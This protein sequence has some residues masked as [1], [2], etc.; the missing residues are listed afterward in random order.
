MKVVN[1]IVFS[2]ALL[3]PLMSFAQKSEKA[4]SEMPSDTSKQEEKNKK[5]EKTYSD[6]VNDSTKT[7]TGLV[8]VHQ[9]EDKYYFEI[10]DSVFGRDIM[11][12]TRIAKTP[13]G[14]G[15]GGEQANRQVIRFENG[16]KKKVFI[17]VVNFVNV[18]ADTTQPIHTAVINSNQHP[19]AAAFDIE[20]NRKDTS[21]LI[22]VT[23]FFEDVNQAFSI[24]PFFKQYY[25][26]QK[27]EKGSC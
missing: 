8:T 5:K 11:A 3:F 7:M 20:I 9:S 17:R 21:V 23:S 4:K 16:P 13:T 10:P 22:D 12:I 1:L 24:S 27:L 14:A 26:L 18:S 6:F 2:L 15:Y 25:K 19:I